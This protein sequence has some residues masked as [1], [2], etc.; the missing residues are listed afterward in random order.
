MQG[1]SEEY[2]F[3]ADLF[4]LMPDSQPFQVTDFSVAELNGG[5][6]F[7]SYKFASGGNLRETGAAVSGGR[8]WWPWNSGKCHDATSTGLNKCPGFLFTFGAWESKTSFY[9]AF[10]DAECDEKTMVL[11]HQLHLDQ[12]EPS[13]SQHQGAFQREP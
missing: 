6:D 12:G 4:E 9:E 3:R 5:R 13:R 2:Q 7:G 10:V 8:Q 11:L 1:E